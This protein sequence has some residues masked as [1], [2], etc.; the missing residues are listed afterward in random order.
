MGAKSISGGQWASEQYVAPIAPIR[1][2][3][4]TNRT[5]QIPLTEAPWAL[6]Q[7]PFPMTEANWEEMI[8][9]LELAKQPLT[10]PCR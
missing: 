7:I 4:Q 3:A 8:R 10:T 6:L 5:I 1:I 2:A 9:F